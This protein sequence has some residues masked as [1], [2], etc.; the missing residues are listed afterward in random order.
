VKQKLGMS[1]SGVF[2]LRKHP[3]IG[4]YNLSPNGSRGMIPFFN[5]ILA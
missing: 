2:H 4:L 1:T 5:V 3:K